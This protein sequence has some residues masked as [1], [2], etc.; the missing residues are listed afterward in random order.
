MARA[1]PGHQDAHGSALLVLGQADQLL[2]DPPQAARRLG[3]LRPAPR[4][5]RALHLTKYLPLTPSTSGEEARKTDV[6]APLAGDRKKGWAILMPKA[7][8]PRASPSAP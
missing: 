5:L 3:V 1:A 7:R 4:L 8:K 2:A 6:R